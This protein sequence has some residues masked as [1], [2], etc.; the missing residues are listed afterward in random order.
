[1]HFSGTRGS[2]SRFIRKSRVF[3]ESS[4]NYHSKK[5]YTRWETLQYVDVPSKI[6]VTGAK[7]PQAR[8]R[9]PHP[10]SCLF[11]V[12]HDVLPTRGEGGRLGTVR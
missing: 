10:E 6:M 4:P 5:K 11:S 3:E 1:M 7:T 12:V 8:P 2:I 9:A